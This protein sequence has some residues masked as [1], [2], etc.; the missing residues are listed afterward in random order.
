M[1][2]KPEAVPANIRDAVEQAA[3][4]AM[5]SRLKTIISR[6]AD[7]AVK[8]R[9][10]AGTNPITMLSERVDL[11]RQGVAHIAQ[12][13]KVKTI[14]DDTAKLLFSKFT[15]LKTAGFT[16]TQAFELLRAEVAGRA[17]RER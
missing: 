4:T 14:L 7:A 9:V 3:H 12:D 13:A 11:A 1:G 2:I 6:D 10:L 15:A 5:E 8:D 16:E 17:G